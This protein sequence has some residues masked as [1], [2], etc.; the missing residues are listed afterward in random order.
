MNKWWKLAI[1]GIAIGVV[2]VL[3]DQLYLNRSEREVHLIPDGYVGPVVIVWDRKDGELSSYEKGMRLYRIPPS[4]VL[5]TQ[6][7]SNSGNVFP[8]DDQYFYQKA[9][10][11]RIEIPVRYDQGRDKRSPEIP[12]VMVYGQ[13]GGSGEFVFNGR[14]EW[15]YVRSYV[16]G[17][18]SDRSKLLSARESL[19]IKNS[20]G[21]SGKTP[22]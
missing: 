14:T 7:Q 1:L 5:F 22:K 4:G 8:G 17:P 6:F 18:L 21:R 19:I 3:V 12:K 20:L 16:V 9:D 11:S 15:G 10:G 2:A 13:Q